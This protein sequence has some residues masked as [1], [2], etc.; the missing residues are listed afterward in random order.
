MR[1]NGRAFQTGALCLLL[2]ALPLKAM[3]LSYRGGKGH[4]R[5]AIRARSTDLRDLGEETSG[6]WHEIVRFHFSLAIF[7]SKKVKQ[8][9]RAK[10]IKEIK[11]NLG[12]GED[13]LDS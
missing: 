1:S 6:G 13:W 9:R 10:P 5:K 8:E 3:I 4:T 2:N 7:A 11:K 12:T